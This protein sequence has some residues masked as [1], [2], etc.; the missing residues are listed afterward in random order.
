MKTPQTLGRRRWLRS[1]GRYG[2]ANKGGTQQLLERL[3][4]RKL[5]EG[6][7]LT[8]CLAQVQERKPWGKPYGLQR[9]NHPEDASPRLTTAQPLD[10]SS[11]GVK[12]HRHQG[13]ADHND[14]ASAFGRRAVSTTPAVGHGWFRFTQGRADHPTFSL[15]RTRATGGLLETPSD[16]AGRPGLVLL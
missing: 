14:S 4:G 7:H 5:V 3:R 8:E 6:P 15:P 16:G 11:S 2:A 9:N 13:A 12:N 10:L 1:P